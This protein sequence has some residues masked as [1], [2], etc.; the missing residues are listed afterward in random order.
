MFIN[1]LLLCVWG[2]SHISHILILMKP[3]R[4]IHTFIMTFCYYYRWFD[5]FKDSPFCEFTFTAGLLEYCICCMHINSGFRNIRSHFCSRKTWNVI[6][7]IEAYIYQRIIVCVLDTLWVRT[8]S[9]REREEGSGLGVC[10]VCIYYS[11]MRGA[12]AY[13][14]LIRTKKIPDIFFYSY[15]LC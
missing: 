5:E 6:T 9:E 4:A 3:W 13:V 2:P 11:K 10:M 8:L 1:R 15:V 12:Q 14:P 7:S